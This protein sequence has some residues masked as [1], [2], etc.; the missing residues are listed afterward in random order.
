MLKL[1]FGQCNVFPC[2]MGCADKTA[3]GH[4]DFPP[5]PATIAYSIHYVFYLK[6]AGAWRFNP[7]DF[8]GKPLPLRFGPE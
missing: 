6:H 3:P 7:C 2:V 8:F 5:L 1:S 4:E